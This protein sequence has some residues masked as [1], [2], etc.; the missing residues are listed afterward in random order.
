[1]KTI[2]VVGIGTGT[3]EH[4]TI[5]AIEALNRADVLFVPDKGGGRSDLADVRGA[6]IGRF[7]RQKEPRLIGYGLPRH[8]GPDQS[9]L[10]ETYDLLIADISEDGTGAFLVWGDPSLFD[11]T[12]TVLRSL[13][14]T[15]KIEVFPGISAF[16]ALTAAH[17]IALG[18]MGQRVVIAAG[19]DL[20]PIETDTVVMFDQHLAFRDA[21]PDLHIFWGAYLA[22]PH[23][24]LV[25]GRLGDVAQRIVAMR[26]L[27]R[28]HHGWIMDTYLLRPPD[29]G[30][31]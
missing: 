8:H 24:I 28:N 25:S 31:R 7:V 3:A 22:T 14:Q 16:Q 4:M 1:M 19:E 9:G 13:S 12:L 27:S 6:I 10:I 18:R 21:D 11:E 29:T 5:G 2:L 26:A 20:G 17:G 15:V 30:T 23:E